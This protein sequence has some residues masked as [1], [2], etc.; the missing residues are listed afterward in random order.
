LAELERP[1]RGA[2]AVGLAFAVLT[3]AWPFVEERLAAE[4]GVRAL[5]FAFLAATIGSLFVARSGLPRDLSLGPLDSAAFIGLPLAAVL[6]GERAFLLLFPAWLYAA[7]A[8]IFAASLRGGGS[9]VERAAL[10]LEPFAPAA[11][12]RPYCRGVTAFWAAVFLVN[13]LGIA[14]LALFAPPAWW[15]AYTGWI[16]WLVFAA[17]SAVEFVVRKVHFRN[18]DGGPIDSAFEFFF[19]ADG[20][21]MGRRANAY[22]GEMRRAQGRPERG[23]SR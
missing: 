9:L 11:I 17:L 18:Y 23:R 12:I 7:L 10:R 20:N 16:C 15:R 13:A 5:A 4:L 1:G 6:T 22:K 14:A 2:L 3:L 21:E 8:R 19:P